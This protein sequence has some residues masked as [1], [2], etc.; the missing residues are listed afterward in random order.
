[1]D[2]VKKNYRVDKRAVLLTGF[3]AAGYPLYYIGLRN[4]QR[5]NALVARAC[6]CDLEIVKTI[7]VTDAVRKLPVLIFFSK[8]GINPVYSKW[9]PVAKQSWAGLR[10]LRENGCT[11]VKIDAVSG[12]HHR[13]PD[14]AHAFWKKYLP[15]GE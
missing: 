15:K 8:T 13:R 11:K 2:E 6:N 4:P 9:N 3:S 5:F 1:M 14:V 7:P 10:Y 12:G